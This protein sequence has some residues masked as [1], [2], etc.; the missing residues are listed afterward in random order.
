MGFRGSYSA[1]PALGDSVFDLLDVVFPGIR[2]ARA[3]GEEFGA[4][5]ESVS[6]PFVGREA[7]G[8]VVAHVGLMSFP[9]TVGGQGVAAGA[10][11]GVA[12]HPERRRAGLYRALMEELLGYAAGRHET[13]VLTTSHPEYFE[14]F[15]FRVVPES[16]FRARLRPRAGRPAARLLDLPGRAEDRT[17]MRRLLE[18]RAP[19]SRLLGL[20]PELACWAF[21][22]FHSPIRYLAELDVAVVAERRGDRLVLFDVV[23]PR[24]PSLDELLDGLGEAVDEVVACFATD[25]LGG[26]FEAE[27]HDLAGGPLALQPGEVGWVLMV[28]G[29][30]AAEGRPLM[31]PRPARC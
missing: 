2:V 8:R 11:H 6:T 17:L 7:D 18:Q 31:L 4:T 12:T 29:P 1:E 14:P 20:G 10:V 13:L 28:R 5:W 19:V 23:G 9:L 27:A 26:P 24:V 22:E 15:G 21:Y 3:R 25:R 16:I 30:F